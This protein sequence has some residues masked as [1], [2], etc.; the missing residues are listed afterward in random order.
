MVGAIIPTLSS[1]QDKIF[2]RKHFDLWPLLWSNETKHTWAA[3]SITQRFMSHLQ[4]RN[5]FL[6]VLNLSLY[7]FCHYVVATY[8][9]VHRCKSSNIQREPM[10][11]RFAFIIPDIKIKNIRIR[12]GK[13]PKPSDIRTHNGTID[14]AYS[15]KHGVKGLSCLFVLP[16][17]DII[18]SVS[19]EYMC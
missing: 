10:L 2:T 3:L 8:K 15:L 16:D 9:H 5:L 7:Q 4:N 19:T 13:E 17:F 11:V 18:D 6:P 1:A 12:Y 14:H